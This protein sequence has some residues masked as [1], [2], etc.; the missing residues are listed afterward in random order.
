MNDDFSQL[1]EQL[2]GQTKEERIRTLEAAMNQATDR[3]TM[4]QLQAMLEDER[5]GGKKKGPLIAITGLLLVVIAGLIFYFVF[6]PPANDTPDQ[7][8]SSTS[9][10]TPGSSISANSS[11]DTVESSTESSD[12]TESSSSEDLANFPY[13]V[14][15]SEL[16]KTFYYTSSVNLPNSVN[17]DF[18][19]GN[20]GTAEFIFERA[21]G[22]SDSTIFSVTHQNIPT[23][24]KRVFT[25][26]SYENL[27]TVMVNTEIVFG[28]VIQDDFDRAADY[29]SADSMYAF[30]NGD[31]SVSL[32]TPNYAGNMPTENDA[33]IM[34]ELR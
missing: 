29:S 8:N 16:S 34:V 21:D 4:G 18:Q 10:T 26:G 13:Q 6:L 23:T 27:K 33:D 24:Q 3:A 20:T 14:P 1:K 7:A 17:I 30:Y 12:D 32:L 2:K 25:D 11:E 28:D 5:N 19:D 15:V 22:T 9:S 31:G